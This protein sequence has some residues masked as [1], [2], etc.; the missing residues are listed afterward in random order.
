MQVL[1]YKAPDASESDKEHLYT[2]V[3]TRL[4]QAASQMISSVSEFLSSQVKN[5]YYYQM[6]QYFN[7]MASSSTSTA[8]LTPDKVCQSLHA[9]VHHKW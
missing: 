5:E 4:T 1:R 2:L 8:N 9:V 3:V 6:E 7:L